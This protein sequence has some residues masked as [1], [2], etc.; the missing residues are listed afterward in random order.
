M[1]VKAV[2][3]SV[4]FFAAYQYSMSFHH[5]NSA[6][7]WLPDAILLSALLLNS[8]RTWWIY[9]LIPLPFRFFIGTTPDDSPWW[10][11][12]SAY[13]ND[14]IKA[15]IGAAILRRFSYGRPE[16]ATVREYVQFVIVAVFA[17]P[18]LSAFAGA[19]ARYAAYGDDYWTAWQSWFLGDSLANV[20]LTPAIVY[21]YVQGFNAVHH[22]R[23]SRMVEAAVLF[24]T[25]I[26]I[27]AKLLSG[28]F[29]NSPILIF[30]PMPLL[31][32]TV[33][34]FGPL[35]VTSAN[36]IVTGFAVWYADQGHGPFADGGLGGSM[37]WLQL[38]YYVRSVLLVT[39]AVLIAER[40]K[41]LDKL[42]R[43][44]DQI[45]ALAG[46]L[47]S[48]HEDERRRLA[49]DLHDGLGQTLALIHL[50]T[51]QAQREMDQ[52]E[53][54]RRNLDGISSTLDNAFK[55]IRAIASNL[56][57]AQLDHLGL[58]GSVRSMIRKL[59][60]TTTIHLDSTM[61]PV[62]GI[63]SPDAETAIYRIVQE[64]LNNVIKHSHATAAS[65]TVSLRPDHLLVEINDNGTGL[66]TTTADNERGF[67]LA[68][69]RERAR[70]L[71][72]EVLI[73]SHRDHGTCLS[74]RLPISHCET[75]ALS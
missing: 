60:E 25:L 2:V 55:E 16:L 9:I 13:V 32:Y 68:G 1:L 8:P 10:F 56:R 61:D 48:S 39:M 51:A 41:T 23:R 50:R 4:A 33:I 71:G 72:G 35:A 11:L 54:L 64:G 57:P 49:G 70:L 29:G 43:S 74:L 3:F 47:L 27:S 59:S 18:A 75:E 42:A 38:F 58:A 65:V 30:L 45:Q 19:A 22:T 62:D 34:R 37:L 44:H 36:L 40:N 46:K 5:S 67:G 73:D 53:K 26:V 6:P 14:T 21:W 31:L 17:M 15:I 20:I 7:L 63:L 52:P 24:G 12:L 28:E 69:I 66:Q